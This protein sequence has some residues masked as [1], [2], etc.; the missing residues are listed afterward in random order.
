[1]GAIGDGFSLRHVVQML[2]SDDL[3]IVEGATFIISELNPCDHKGVEKLA[4]RILSFPDA[5]NRYHG[6]KFFYYH[7]A[8]DSNSLWPL[9]RLLDDEAYNPRRMAM[10]AL[11]EVGDY[12]WNMAK[13]RKP[14]DETDSKLVEAVSFFFPKKA[15]NR[16]K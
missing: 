13:R 5:Q 14:Q 9:I 10:S 8:I 3:D 15:S 7:R 6:A 1:M 12:Y 11:Y 2:K 4:V 16:L